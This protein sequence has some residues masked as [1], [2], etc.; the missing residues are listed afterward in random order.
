MN[1]SVPRIGLFGCL[2]YQSEKTIFSDNKKNQTTIK[3]SK[4]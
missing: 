3:K 2:L 4:L 1:L